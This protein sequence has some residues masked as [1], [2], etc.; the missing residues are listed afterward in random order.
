M[1]REKDVIFDYIRNGEQIAKSKKEYITYSIIIFNSFFEYGF[2]RRQSSSSSMGQRSSY[3]NEFDSSENPFAKVDHYWEY[4]TMVL[5][6]LDTVRYINFKYE[7]ASNSKEKAL[8]WIML[9][10]NQKEEL[11][12]VFIELFNNNYI[13]QLYHRDQS[14]LWVNKKDLLDACDVIDKKAMYISS[15]LLDNFIDFGKKKEEKKE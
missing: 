13:L 12:T 3:T 9:A 15:P 4:L 2:L 5:N 7:D 1:K 10:L 8:G 11:K 14:Y 6:H